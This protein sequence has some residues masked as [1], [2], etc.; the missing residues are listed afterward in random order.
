LT[1]FRH[2]FYNALPGPPADSLTKGHP[3]IRSATR[4]LF[5]LAVFSLA[6]CAGTA[7]GAGANFRATSQDARG[8]TF[9]ITPPSARF[10]SVSVDVG[11]YVRVS[12][13]GGYVS[14]EP[15]RPGLPV[16]MIPVG[17]PDG[18]TAKARVASADWAERSGLPPPLPVVRQTY[19]GEDPETHLPVSQ[20]RYEPDP[21]IYGRTDTWPRDPVT[22]GDGGPLGD[23]WM[24]PAM[25]R[26]VRYDPAHKRFLILK[27]MTLRVDFVAATSGDLKRR[28][29]VRPGADVGAWE[30][31]RGAMLGNYPSARAF[32][33]RATLAPRTARPRLAPRRAAANP[34]FKVSVTATGWSSVSFASLAAAG[35]PAG[36][37]ISQIGVW[38]RGY[39]DVG[40]S[41]TSTPIPVVARDNNSDSLFDAGDAITF[42]ARNLRDRVGAQSIENRYSYANVYWVT[43]T[44]AAAAVPDTISGVIA[45]SPALP[46]S[47]QDTIHLEQNQRLMTWPNNTVGSPAENVEYLFW[48]DGSDPDQ[49]NTSIPFVHP[50]ASA[51]FRIRARYQGKEGSTHRMN[52]YYQSSTGATDTLATSHDFFGREIYLLDTGFTIP[53]SHIGP[54]TNHYLHTGFVRF[55][56][57]STFLPGSLSFLDWVEVTYSRLYIADSNRLEFT[58][59][60]TAGIVELHVGGFTQPAIEVYDVT[61]PTASLRVTGTTVSSTG[62]GVYEVSFRTDATAGTRRFVA[63]VSGSEVA[64]AASAVRQDAPSNLGTPAPFPGGAFARSILITPDAFLTPANR[65]ADFR[66]SQGYVVEVASVQD[67][68]DEFNGGIKSGIAIRR[69]FQHAYDTWTP[70]PAF[71]GL[72]GDASVDYRHDMPASSVDWVPTYLAFETIAGPNGAELVANDS[73]YVL[74]LGRGGTTAA[75]FTPS[76]FLGRI[77]ASSA[78]ELDQFV[79]KV[80]QYENFQPTDTWRGRQFLVSDDEYSSTIFFNAGYCFQPAEIAFKSASQAMA[81]TTNASASG[82]DIATEFFDL[83]GLT[84]QHAVACADNINPGCRNLQCIVNALRSVGGGVDSF[85]NELARGQLIFNIEAHAN[86]YLIAHEQIYDPRDWGDLS[87]LANFGRPN[88]YMMWGCHANQF[89][90]GPFGAGDI[91]SMDAIGEQWVMA[92]SAGSIGGLGSAAFEIID[93]NAAMNGFMADAFYSTPPT[94]VPVPGEPHQARWIMGEIVGQGFVKNANT[95]SFTQ[96]AMNL[97]VNLF[98]DPMTRM[99]ALP[100]RIFAVTENG[101]PF[102]ANGS[103]TIDTP[104]VT[105]SVTIVAKVRDEAGLQKTDL[106]ERAVA[107]GSIT[108]LD[109]TLFSVAISDTGRAH[110]LTAR[111]RPHIDNYDLLVRSTDTNGRQQ[112]FALEV[113]STVRYLANGSVIV[114]GAFI[115]S[116]AALR[117]EVTTPIPVTADSLTLLLDGVP[118][119]NVTKT[120]L[121]ATNRRWALDA[122][123]KDLVQALHTLDVEISGRAGVFAQGTFNVETGLAIRRVVVVSPRL[124]GSGCDGSVFQFEL[125]TPSPKVLLLLMSVAGRRV[126]SLELPGQAGFN[127]YC[128]DGRDSQGNVAA[129]G[130]YFYR[131][132]AEDGAGHRVSQDGRMIRTR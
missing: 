66:R 96:Q 111:Y 69:Y 4:R 12:V 45:A 88:F 101:A 51:P 85:F 54:G 17:V 11:V 76:I 95:G 25:V 130:L 81:D 9:E 113:R 31:V 65:L 42:Y 110:T 37:S 119:A 105:D 16:F 1:P 132:S 121:D 79:S 75:Q 63:V 103:L 72:L 56:S 38:E 40:D 128:W 117:A 125:T 107:T 80:I 90:D 27:R 99:D 100:P 116:N 114:N 82:S 10:D 129:N 19:V 109:S 89:P 93:T 59:G 26:L 87:R 15:G 67:I 120:A 30:K 131:L 2:G 122:P 127:V 57:G 28:P 70:R 41:A 68:Y 123:P 74:N 71:A 92:P 86:R 46:T 36:I 43:W 60:S 115:E 3:D 94:P 34:E 32:P 5:P 21:G 24:M 98:G 112:T 53:G 77:P 22:L 118:L 44:G 106:A 48:T 47:F 49:F 126:A 50:D 20:D 6:F 35:F 18:M 13:P 104:G 55:P 7:S 58:S 39:D 33:R 23:S 97:T 84:D 108:P 8:V 64:I 62:P 102:A 83:Q 52:A 61:T 29:A 78:T 91:D 73:H 14:E 124:M